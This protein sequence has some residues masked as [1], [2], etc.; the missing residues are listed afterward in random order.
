MKIDKESM[1]LYV[2]TDRTWL[3]NHSL[4][5][6][7]EQ[8]IKAGATFVQLREKDISYKEFVQ[9][10]REI[11]EVTDL[12]KIPFVINDNIE[13]AQAVDADGVHIGQGDMNARKARK[14]LGED[15]MI[16][17]SAQ[18]ASQAI[19]A[20]QAGADYIGAGAIF[21]TSTKKDAENISLETLKKICQSVSIPVVAIGGIN[22]T[23]VMKLKGSGVS[24][25][26]VI[27]AIFSKPDISTATKNLRTLSEQM[28]DYGV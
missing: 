10:A 16:G 13:V 1:L 14:I 15:K 6:Q 3:G 18:S 23:N 20:Q 7:V 11:K 9:L 28:V 2:I 5:D 26:S 4:K 25:I 24:G 27:S 21:S 12:Y 8:I 19:E 22:E 17:V